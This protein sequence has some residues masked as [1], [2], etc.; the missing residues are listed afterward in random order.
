MGPCKETDG[1]GLGGRQGSGGSGATIGCPDRALL[2]PA[3]CQ[4]RP[5][6]WNARLNLRLQLS[7]PLAVFRRRPHARRRLRLQH[8][9]FTLHT[10]VQLHG[11]RRAVSVLLR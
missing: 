10:G 6:S 11:G 7:E 1:C 3:A 8:L 9:H 5:A 4:R 2:P